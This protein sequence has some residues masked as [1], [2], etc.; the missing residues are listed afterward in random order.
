MA[1]NSSEVAKFWASLGI[2][3]DAASLR[4]V[5]M[6]F[7]QIEQRFKK[8]QNTQNAFKLDL[9]AFS[10]DNKALARVLGNA[11]DSISSKVTFQISKFAVNERNLQASILRA[12]RG[13]GGIGVPINISGG[14]RREKVQQ[15]SSSV[16]DSHRFRSERLFSPRLAEHT[17]FGAAN[18]GMRALGPVGLAI[19]ATA[20]AGYAVNK[21]LDAVQDRVI[22]NDT[23]RILLGQSVGGTD[24]RKANAME[25]YKRNSNKYGTDAK[26]GITDFNTA[27]ALQRGNGISTRNA[28]SNYDLFSQRFAVRHL[29]ADQQKAAMRQI[30]QILGKE[31]VGQQDMNALVEG[32]GDPEIKTLVQKAWAARTNYKGDNRSLDYQAA[33]KK[34][35]VTSDD[36]IQAYKISSEKYTHELDEAINSVRANA[37]RLTNDKFWNQFERDGKAIEDATKDRIAAERELESALKPL[38]DA[39]NAAEVATMSYSASAIRWAIKFGGD[40]L[41]TTENPGS[42]R[43]EGN[44]LSNNIGTG[45]V[46]G[47][48]WDSNNMAPDEKLSM[49][50]DSFSEKAGYMSKDDWKKKID[51]KG[52]HTLPDV[53]V[54]PLGRNE[55]I[56]ILAQDMSNP[57]GNITQKTTVTVGDIIVNSTAQNAAGLM[58]DFQAQLQPAMENVWSQA[59][60]NYAKS[61]R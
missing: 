45:S 40:A 16:A 14:H 61:A 21:R 42:L 38:K 17:G 59:Q 19:G 9:K 53:N 43:K 23:N 27:I 15:I 46:L 13:L 48:I 39:M 7:N 41:G 18:F 8:L 31:K 35:Q 32:G 26:E 24:E 30:T 4:K 55:D 6:L 37:Q 36:L 29:S 50:L 20:A 11:L 54:N 34:G 33:Q 2:K 60:L 57:K 12:T 52:T 56:P 47:M 58:Q 22:S 25:W 1:G 5:D 10:V 51:A 44:V 49:M 3:V 28:L